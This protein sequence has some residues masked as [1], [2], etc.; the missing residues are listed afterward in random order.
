MVRYI[1]RQR[2]TRHRMRAG[3]AAHGP[4]AQQ[5]LLQLA[6]CCSCLLLL[7]APPACCSCPLLRLPARGPSRRAGLPAGPAHQSGGGPA[8][9]PGTRAL[10]PG[11]AAAASYLVRPEEREGR[12]GGGFKSVRAGSK[13]GQRCVSLGRA[14]PDRLGRRCWPG[15]RGCRGGSGLY[16]GS[17]PGPWLPA[18]VQPAGRAA[19]RGARRGGNGAA[20]GP[21][22][23]GTGRLHTGL[24][25]V[26][27]LLLTG[28]A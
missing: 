13:H 2:S 15:P 20:H 21:A 7:P 9:G 27:A 24:V 3:P 19:W 14:D 8:G 10:Q 4:A 1:R 28:A 23:R 6:A 12:G 26:G 5:L 16:G 25:S 17:L 22:A 11:A 18:R